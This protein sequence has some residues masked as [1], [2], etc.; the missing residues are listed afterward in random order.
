MPPKSVEKL[1][2]E[3]HSASNLFRSGQQRTTSRILAQLA[4]KKLSDQ[5][6]LVRFH[7]ILLFVSAYPQS[8]QIRR[9]AE[10]LLATV[11]GQVA[12]LV[13]ANADI[14][15]LEHPDV[16]GI[17]GTS[18]TDTFSYYIV[19]WLLRRHPGQITLDWGWFEDENRLAATWPRFMPL[20]EEDT[21]V[22]AN[23]PYSTWLAAAKS[24]TET[25]VSW[26]IRHFEAL[27]RSQTEKAELYDSLQLYVR[28][29]PG[30]AASRT[31]LRLPVR[32]HFY[33]H[34]PLIQR[35]DLSFATELQASPAPVKTISSKHGE[36]IL[37]LARA[38]ST[39]RYRE[40]YGFTHGDPKS[41]LQVSFGRGVSLYVIG[42]PPGRRLPLRAYH[43]AMI[44][45]NGIP[46]GYFEG[47]S[48]FERME[49]GFNIYYSF[50]QGETAWIYAHTLQTFHHLLG[51]TTFSI[52]PYQVGLGNEEAIQSGAF[53]FYRKLGFRPIVP[54]IHQLALAEEKKLGTRASYRTPARVLRQLAASHMIFELRPSQAGNWDGFAIR[55]LALAVQKRMSVKS[56]ADTETVRRKSIDAVSRALGMREEKW[57]KSELN[58]LVGLGMVMALIPDLDQWSISEKLAATQIIRAKAGSDESQYLKLMQRHSRLRQ[59]M[60]RIGTGNKRGIGK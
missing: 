49:S 60:I 59:E 3:L 55:N 4:R 17:A 13:S 31:G 32:N 2:N 51:V 44:F 12:T 7:E 16:S 58:S 54:E 50:R 14:S 53:W 8:S 29:T 28:W 33:H 36:A 40:L 35:R 57:K 27:P 26:L 46:V 6:D 39:I 56:K 45:K 30:Y 9:A 42:L 25:E 34:G 19:S 22:E 20:L 41:V 5:H 11:A 47:L 52:D 15:A 23:I 10:S 24:T 48:L 21:F 43:A 18:V 1:L 37:E 38:A